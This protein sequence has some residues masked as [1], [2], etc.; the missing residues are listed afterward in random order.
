MDVQSDNFYLSEIQT[1]LLAKRHQ[2][3]E[4]IFAHYFEPTHERSD[5]KEYR[6][7]FFRNKNRT[8]FGYK[9]IW[10]KLDGDLRAMASRVVTDET[11]RE[12]MIS[13]DEIL[14][15]IWKRH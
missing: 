10:G 11:Y 15:R 13:D 3:H 7:F 5:G 12:S 9:E 8:I 14:P 4:W 6:I 2:K 1:K